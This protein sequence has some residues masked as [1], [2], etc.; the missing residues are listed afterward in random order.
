MTNRKWKQ[1]TSNCHPRKKVKPTVLSFRRKSN[2]KPSRRNVTSD[3]GKNRRLAVSVGRP[4]RYLR[5]SV[6]SLQTDRVR[7]CRKDSGQSHGLRIA[8]PPGHCQRSTRPNRLDLG[9]S[10]LIP[11]AQTC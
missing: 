3:D 11:V 2:D 9:G 10:S 5:F 4:T 6:C 8:I 7:R 1:A